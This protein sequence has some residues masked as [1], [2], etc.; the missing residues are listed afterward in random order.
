M[1]ILEEKFKA[2][3]LKFISNEKLGELIV[4]KKILEDD[5][6]RTGDYPSSPSM[7]NLNNIKSTGEKAFQRAI[8]NRKETIL[9]Y[10]GLKRTDIITWFDLELPITFN[11]NSRRRCLDLIG[12]SDNVPVICEL[13]YYEATRSNQP[14]YAIV[15]LLVYYYFIHCNYK[16]LDKYDIHHHLINNDFKWKV[17]A[18]KAEPKLLVAANSAYWNYWFKKIDKNTLTKQVAELGKKLNIKIYLFEAVNE[19]FILQKNSRPTF[20]PAV[21]SNIWQEI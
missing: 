12:F 3:L 20:N 10:K 21:I 13:K 2:K 8:F 5:K 16:K 1:K 9:N 14:I 18:E 17:I 19:D 7:A 11:K 6:N 4:L 15:E